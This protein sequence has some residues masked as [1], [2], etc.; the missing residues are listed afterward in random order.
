MGEKVFLVCG[1]GVYGTGHSVAGQTVVIEVELDEDG[2]Y[3]T[4]LAPQA[5]VDKWPRVKVAGSME[6]WEECDGP[7]R[8]LNHREWMDLSTSTRPLRSPKA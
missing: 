6:M 1:N 8:L 3:G 4:V 2:H 5:F 7:A